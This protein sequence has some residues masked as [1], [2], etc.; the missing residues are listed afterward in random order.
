MVTCESNSKIMVYGR[1]IAN[2]TADNRIIFTAPNGNWTGI[3]FS[4]SGANNSSVSY[5]DINYAKSPILTTSANVSIANTAIANSS[6]QNYPHDAAMTFYGSAPTI[7]NVVIWGRPDSKNGVRFSQG[8][9]GSMSN[10]SIQSLGDGNGIIIEGSSSP[11]ISNNTING[12]KYHGILVPYSGGF[13]VIRDNRIESN[14]NQAYHG[15]RIDNSQAEIKG[16]IISGHSAGFWIDNHSYVR[17]P[18]SGDGLNQIYGNVYGIHL[19]DESD[20][21]FGYVDPWAPSYH[22][23][24]CNQLYNN[25]SYNVHMTGFS[26]MWAHGN[27]WYPTPPSGIYSGG[28]GIEYDCFLEYSWDCGSFVSCGQGLMMSISGA[29]VDDNDRMLRDAQIARMKR[30]WTASNALFRKVL[31]RDAND[32]QLRMAL[33]GLYRNFVDTRDASLVDLIER[34]ASKDSETRL[35]ASRLLLKAKTLTGQLD[36]ATMIAEGLIDTYPKSETEKDALLFLSFLG[37]Y[38]EHRRS[39]AES[40]R[41]RLFATYGD[42]L[43]KGLLAA[44]PRETATQAS[45]GSDQVQAELSLESTIYPNPFNPATTISFTL[46]MDGL[47]TLRIYDVL[48]RVVATLVNE[49]RLA[50]PHHVLWNASNV[51]SGVY[52]SRLETKNGTLVSK[53]LLVR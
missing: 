51:P 34:R 50:G 47:V 4:G 36:E 11:T 7:S 6:F 14:I 33:R 20:M 48:G 15:I 52:F 19:E 21:E 5:A 46:P 45:G 25:S 16:N 22:Y 9:Y 2:G 35:T 10:S 43:D 17:T 8:S 39:V 24:S 30:D 28:S 40:S 29:T 49:E 37:G 1:L 23:G 26:Y 31:E 32:F 13:P 12:C 41:D 53:L 44:I 27:Y 38:D 42:S 3:E 18:Y